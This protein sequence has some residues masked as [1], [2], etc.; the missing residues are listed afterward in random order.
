MALWSTIGDFLDQSGW[1][2]ALCEAGIATAGVVDSFLKVSH[3]TRTRRSHQITA[4]VLSMLQQDAWKGAMRATDQE[5]SFEEWRQLMITK[6]PTFQYWDLILEFEILVMIF[7]RAHR[8]KDFKLYI[9]SL[10]ALTP[11]FFAL[12]H[13]NYARWVPIHIR[14]MKSL[15]DNVK[16][17]FERCWVLRKTSSKFSCIP[18]DQGH[19]Q[20]NALV[21][22]SGGAVGLTE[23]PTA[24]RRWMVAGPEQARLLTEFEN[25]FMEEEHIW[26]RQHEQGLSAKELF[27]KNS[28]SLYETMMRMGNPFKDD[29]L[30]LLALDSRSCATEN[31]I[32][33]VKTI[34]SI[35]NSQ[36]QKYVSD[37]IKT[38]CVSIHHPIKKN[39][40]PLWKRQSSKVATKNMQKMASLRS[41]CNLFSHL[42]IASKFRDGDL[43]DF[44]HMRITH[45][46]LLFQSME[47]FVYQTKS[48]TC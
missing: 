35:G 15:P 43:D 44:F 45:G 48:Q 3:L 2:T 36:Y 29:C 16:D 6:C 12:D 21:K 39:S 30:E 1:T 34:K 8:I 24:F 19:E 22:G 4:L 33:T 20:N 13:I 27:K 46:L 5:V 41:D 7:V 37:V 32:K 23:N 11:W 40:L 28:N 25:Q 31:V 9:E 10:E 17:E 26:G 38:K 18:I 14:D 42:Y 47:N